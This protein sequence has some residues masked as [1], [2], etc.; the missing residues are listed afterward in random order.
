[1]ASGTAASEAEVAAE[2]AAE[3]AELADLLAGLTPAQWDEPTLCARWQVRQVVGHLIAGYDPRLTVWRAMFGAVRHRFDFDRFNDANAR[4]HEAG[5]TS[6]ELVDALRAVD[7]AQ[8]IATFVP[9]GRRLHEHVVHHQDVRRPLGR[10][11]TMPEDRLR[12]VLDVA[13]APRGPEKTARCAKDL[14]FVATDLDWQA[15][16]GPVVEGPAEALLLALSQRPVG[17]AELS[18]DGLETFRKRL[19]RA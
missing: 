15:G 13:R 5:R 6:A 18:G 19:G 7:L 8:G 11:R 4:A 10:P 3:L 17:L 12:I 1:M 14:T 16:R 9:A 2:I